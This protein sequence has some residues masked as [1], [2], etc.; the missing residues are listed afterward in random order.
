MYPPVTKVITMATK[1][2]A[3]KRVFACACVKAQCKGK[4]HHTGSKVN[5]G[6]RAYVDVSL[7]HFVDNHMTYS[8]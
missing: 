3:V 6:S 5:V 4:D 1:D 7:V 2:T 8:N